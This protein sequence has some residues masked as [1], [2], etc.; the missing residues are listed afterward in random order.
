MY[1]RQA[2]QV[3]VKD[4]SYESVFRYIKTGLLPLN[5]QVWRLENYV[6]ALG[7]RGFKR[8]SGPWEQVYALS[9]IHI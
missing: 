5:E 1:K 4:F 2:L 6:R 9:L 8:W 7:I 3:V